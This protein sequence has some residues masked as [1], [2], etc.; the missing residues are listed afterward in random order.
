MA[1]DTDCEFAVA[2]DKPSFQG[3]SLPR[4][5]CQLFYWHHH[6]LHYLVYRSLLHTLDFPSFNIAPHI[7]TPTERCNRFWFSFFHADVWTIEYGF[8]SSRNCWEISILFLAYILVS[9]TFLK[10]TALARSFCDYSYIHYTEWRQWG[11]NEW[12]SSQLLIMLLLW[13]MHLK[14]NLMQM[15]LCFYINI[16]SIAQ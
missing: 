14:C 11:M 9:H 15:V 10:V 4:I 1:L 13:G 7:F 8:F 2:S 12:L 16:I 6:H 5:W 3:Q